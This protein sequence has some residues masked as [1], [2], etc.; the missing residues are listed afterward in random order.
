VK[1]TEGSIAKIAKGEK[2][3]GPIVQIL[4]IKL[5]KTQQPSGQ[6][7]G[8]KY[9][10]ILSDGVN[11]YTAFVAS[12][13]ATLFA[14]N[15]IQVFSIVRLQEY[16]L[17]E[18]SNTKFLILSKLELIQ[19]FSS[20]I[21]NPVQVGSTPQPTPEKT[22]VTPSDT[23]PAPSP[24]SPMKST[25]RVIS[26]QQGQ[27]VFTDVSSST[28]E[29]ILPIKNLNPY[30]N[31]WTIRARVTSK[32][33]MKEFPR[34]TGTG[35]GKLFSVELIDAAGDEIR[36]T[37][38]TEVADKLYPILEVGHV[39]L[40]SRGDVKV[41]NKKFTT[42]VHPFEITFTNTTVVSPVSEDASTV[43]IPSAHF[44][45]VP[46]EK[47][48]SM[49]KNDMVD[50]L[51][52]V[53]QISDVQSFTHKTSGRDLTKRT[54]T[55]LDNTAYSIEVTLWGDL[56]STS[57]IDVGTVVAI[58]AAR[59]G[60]FNGKSLS[61][62]A[63]SQIK[64]SPDIPD[65]KK[66]SAWYREGGSSSSI[67][68]ISDGSG[69]MSGEGKPRD[70]TVK[71]LAAAQQEQLGM[72][73]Q[74]DFFNCVACITTIK[75]DNRISYTACPKCNSKVNVSTDGQYFCSKCNQSM[76]DCV[77]NYT[78]RMQIADATGS[79]WVTCFRETAKLIMNGRD[80]T[81]LITLQ[82]SGAG[83]EFNMAFDD[84]AH[85]WYLFRV[86]AHLD[87]YR[88]EVRVQYS[89]SSATPIDYSK[90]CHRL[91]SIIDSYP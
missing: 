8:D 18:F 43:S 2:V 65:A 41:A 60:T 19:A 63:S 69:G 89:I 1:L 86:R 45:F 32:T 44:S 62:S 85:K 73:T 24:A 58:R 16:C 91:L 11:I 31:V 79:L 51:G 38:F 64:V 77:E 71:T 87:T 37:A 9:R 72:G 82:T 26:S 34:K 46:I 48:G 3:Y 53:T 23:A 6:A 47:I 15:A 39:Y 14:S 5:S 88:E 49:E 30:Q 61:T 57:N 25:N 10:L 74:A 40:I 50:V 4:D 20:K 42:I 17:T 12:Q 59:V 81:E 7:H 75:H 33:P 83:D 90:E 28:S 67:V 35:T 78:L 66:L 76:P 36:A 21:G 70:E 29:T 22:E 52:V 68:A 56:A 13:S 27:K 84:A 55:L 54:M 80:A